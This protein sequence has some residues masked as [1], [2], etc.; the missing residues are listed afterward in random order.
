MC[1]AK[2]LECLESSELYGQS[3]LSSSELQKTWLRV[4]DKTIH[5]YINICSYIKEESYIAGD[6]FL[7]ACF[8]VFLQFESPLAEYKATKEM[9]FAEKP[10]IPSEK[11][12][13]KLIRLDFIRVWLLELV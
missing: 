5:S 10:A 11:N 9:T 6:S 3:I 2:G 13:L 12:R 4:A 7:T 1:I 8:E